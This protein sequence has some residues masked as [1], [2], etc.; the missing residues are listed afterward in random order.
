MIF[1]IVVHLLVGLIAGSIFAVRTLLTLVAF[2]LIES[3]VLMLGHGVLTGLFW[4]LGSLGAVQI[5][6]LAG[7]WLRS[8]IEY[9]GI[10]ESGAE[11]RRHR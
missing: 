6:Y 4:S 11:S 8:V 5:G 10:A 2:I 7:V 9:A 1:V 3:F